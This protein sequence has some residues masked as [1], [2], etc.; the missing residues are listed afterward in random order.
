M[1]AIRLDTIDG[2][3]AAL[4]VFLWYGQAE[5]GAVTLLD[6]FE[7]KPLW[8]GYSIRY[9]DKALY[10]SGEK[11][12]ADAD[13]ESWEFTEIAIDFRPD[14]DMVLHE[15]RQETA[16]NRPEPM[17]PEGA[18]LLL[19]MQLDTAKPIAPLTDRQYLLRL[20]GLTTLQET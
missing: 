16:A 4:P 8:S 10:L 15:I 18:E 14:P 12:S 11:L 6:T 7:V 3:T 2:S 19:E 13:A 9:A 20:F 17:Y 1:V 5:D